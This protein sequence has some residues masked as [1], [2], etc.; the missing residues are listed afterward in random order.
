MNRCHCDTNAVLGQPPDL[1]AASDDRGD[2]IMYLLHHSGEFC[3]AQPGAQRLGL[4]GG[5]EQA[6]G[7]P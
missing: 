3:L 4:I 7:V 1:I 2:A 6:A 5:D